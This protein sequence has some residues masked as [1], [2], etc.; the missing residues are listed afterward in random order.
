MRHHQVAREF[1]SP[2]EVAET[3]DRQPLGF[4]SLR[5][6]HESALLDMLPV[7]SQE[8]AELV[9]PR[10]PR[11]RWIAVED[12]VQEETSEAITPASPQ[13]IRAQLL[14]LD[15]PYRQLSPVAQKR[16]AREIYRQTRLAEKEE[17]A[18]SLTAMDS[19]LDNWTPADAAATRARRARTQAK[20]SAETTW[21]LVQAELA[22]LKT[23]PDGYRLEEVARRA[24]E[25][26]LSNEFALACAA[27]RT[28]LDERARDIA[29]GL[30]A[31]IPQATDRAMLYEIAN[32]GI[33]AG[34]TIGADVLQHLEAA[35]ERR[36][37]E[38]AAHGPHAAE[39]DQAHAKLA[40][41][42]ADVARQLSEASPTQPQT[43]TEKE[44]A[45]TRRLAEKAAPAKAVHPVSTSGEA[46]HLLAELCQRNPRVVFKRRCVHFQALTRADQVS[47]VATVLNLQRQ[48]ERCWRKNALVVI[49]SHG[50]RVIPAAELEPGMR[51]VG[52]DWMARKL[53]R[54]A[55]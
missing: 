34:T 6:M 32:A 55:A 8:A 5:A 13:E 51:L 3:A 52:L 29:A 37:A 21:N 7:E 18:A 15:R 19:A 9:A 33:L 50:L 1:V 23:T 27:A 20:Q 44:L 25:A 39:R 24:A 42:T 28:A 35:L 46:D 17:L 41:L 54:A 31:R 12:V 30:N 2:L 45:Q 48:V 10:D 11:R 4:M 53:E 36:E 40:E 26:R 43:P 49:R 16:V 14:R 38:L 22:L 47:F